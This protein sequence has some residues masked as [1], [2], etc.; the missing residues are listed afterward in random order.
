[1]EISLCIP[2]YNNSNFLRECLSFPVSEKR[3]TE[4]IISD[5]SSEDLEEVKKILK[6]LNSP[7]IKLIENPKRLGVYLNKIKSLKE[8]KN[9]WAILFDSD[10]Y[11]D[12][13]YIDSIFS[14]EWDEKKIISPSK[15]LKIDDYSNSIGDYFD[16]RIFCGEIHSDNFHEKRSENPVI[17]ETMLNT[18]NYF[19]PVSSYI[20]CSEKNSINYDTMKISSLDSLTL[21]TDWIKENNSVLILEGLSYNH[22]VHKDS[23]YIKN[24]EKINLREWIDS[25][26]TKIKK[27]K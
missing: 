9:K 7:K 13:N 10:N 23:T 25:C 19:V 18:C 15:I 16:Y 8:C 11:L 26:L 22:R 5:D 21:F 24:S 2:H 3:I 27:M 20:E 6:E 14:V 4:I 17:F 12:K 1:M